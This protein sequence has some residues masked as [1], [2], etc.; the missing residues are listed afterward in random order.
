MIQLF[1]EPDDVTEI[2]GFN[3]NIDIDRLKPSIEV[4]Q[5]T[6]VY[7]IL[8]KQLYDKIYQGGNTGVYSTILN[9]FVRPILAWHSASLFLSLNTIKTNNTGS[10]KLS[11]N[12]G[13]SL[14]TSQ[15]ITNLAMSY[16][17]IATSY[18][19]QFLE[20]MKTA[21]IPEFT[22]LNKKNNGTIWH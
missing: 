20:F 15:E 5:K 1:L 2:V 13:D 21:N 9:E 12:A 10:Y 14:P 18:E 16:K 19:G 22:N 11:G 7:N 17:N 4:A 8:E 6:L 3:G